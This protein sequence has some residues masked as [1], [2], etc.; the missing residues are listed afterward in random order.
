M[1]RR[2]RARRGHVMRPWSRSPDMVRLFKGTRDRTDC[3]LPLGTVTAFYDV[4][5]GI[6]YGPDGAMVEW[7]DARAPVR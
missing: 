7:R 4:R 6:V 3:R 1:S 5:L 2:T